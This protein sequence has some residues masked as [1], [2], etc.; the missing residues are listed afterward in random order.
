[1]KVLHVVFG[2]APDPAG[3]TEIYVEELCR[4]LEP[5]GV[6]AVVAAP[7]PL[8]VAYDH[9]GLPVRRFA[10]SSGEVDLDDLY[11]GGDAHAAAAF[12]RILDEEQPD[13]LH[14]HALT[15]ACS[16]RLIRMAK[17]RR[18]PVVF[19]YHTATVSCQR[20]TLLEWG[21]KPCDGRTSVARCT[22]CTLHG[23][24]LDPTTSGLVG[25]TPE[26]AGEL[27]G[28]AG[29]AGGAWTALRMRSLMRQRTD[30]LIQL[31]TNVDAFVA[32]TP[33]VR[34]LLRLNGV[35]D[36][37]IT[38]S[39]HGVFGAWSG[40]VA[41]KSDGHGET[42]RI[43][44][45][46]RLDPGKGTRLLVEAVRS[47]PDASLSLDIFGVIQNPG[48]AGRLAELQTLASAD[49][50]IRFLPALVHADVVDTLASY[51]LVAVPSQL[52]E[53]GPL[54][55]LEAFAAGVPVIGSSLGGIADKVE[56]GKNGWLVKPYGSLDAWRAA[57]SRCATDGH[58]MNKLKTGIQKPRT[59]T[60]V[61]REMR[62]LYVTQLAEANRSA[63]RAVRRT[64]V[65]AP[66][67]PQSAGGL[68]R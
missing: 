60:D 41:A 37:R 14:Q 61:A 63:G 16:A 56:H 39:S 6:Q 49:P 52:C 53:T 12:E 10:V 40:P 51:D 17:E 38:D 24:G 62:S 67:K 29:L 19:T 59:M 45:L 27:I 15:S 11:G 4:E 33:W 43:A 18:I 25:L 42:L 1:M 22:P 3:G 26:I 50:R 31:L 35:P 5:L 34:E 57:L 47:V 55:V 30:H 36:S 7:G 54:V 20:G 21:R 32:V 68:L 44:H 9:R 65:E 48:D 2:F 64:P 46:G 23:L 13:V 58:L 28:R 66:L 8:D